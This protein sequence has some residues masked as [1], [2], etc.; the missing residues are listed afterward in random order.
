MVLCGFHTRSDICDP[1]LSLIS[2]PAMS[3]VDPEI[4][5]SYVPR[6]PT[7]EQQS[8]INQSLLIEMVHKEM[9]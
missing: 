1:A 7:A 8:V 2:V 6:V 5:L 3:A 9:S 4:K